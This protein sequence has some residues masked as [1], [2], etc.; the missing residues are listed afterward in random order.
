[1]SGS[2]LQSSPEKLTPYPLSPSSPL[3]TPHAPI[4]RH[5]S[6][7]A[8]DSPISSGVCSPA[9]TSQLMANQLSP[10]SQTSS[11]TTVSQDASQ[12]FTSDIG[13]HIYIFCSFFSLSFFFSPYILAESP[14]PLYDILDDPDLVSILREH[15]PPSKIPPDSNYHLPCGSFQISSYYGQSSSMQSQVGYGPSPAPF[16]PPNYNLSP[17]PLTTPVQSHISSPTTTPNPT[18]TAIQQQ[19]HPLSM[20]EKQ[21]SHIQS[22]TMRQPYPHHSQYR[23]SSL[24]LNPLPG[25]PDL[26]SPHYSPH[27]PQPFPQVYTQNPMMYQ[28]SLPL[29]DSTQF[30]HRLSTPQRTHV[31]GYHHNL[32]VSST[33]SATTASPNLYQ[34]L[35]PNQK[36]PA[37]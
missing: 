3:P 13:R 29:I 30:P 19:L 27:S 26:S 11:A 2:V 34:S 37:R 20:Q 8:P 5:S 14:V 1:M 36:P 7:L 33:P 25:Y 23:P 17:S 35:E 15:L 31:P 21:L 32:T 10:S 16:H 4:K 24:P 28:Q 9:M 22:R 12:L 6:S 18:N